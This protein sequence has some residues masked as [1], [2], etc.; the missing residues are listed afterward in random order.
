M[1]TTPPACSK[2]S[3]GT[4][5][6]LIYCTQCEQVCFASPQMSDQHSSTRLQRTPNVRPSWH[7]DYSKLQS[8]HALRLEQGPALLRT[9]CKIHTS[10]RYYMRPAQ[11]DRLHWP[12]HDREI[13][14]KEQHKLH[15]SGNFGVSIGRCCVLVHCS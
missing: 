3:V 6:D 14:K 9:M 1:N 15:K 8:S 10:C 5:A 13:N 7:Q 4:T 11:N 2:A 12:T